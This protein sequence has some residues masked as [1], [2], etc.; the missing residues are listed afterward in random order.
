M[1]TEQDL[2]QDV[3]PFRDILKRVLIVEPDA[4][5]AERRYLLFRKE[6]LGST[7]VQRVSEAIRNIQ[8]VHF[9]AV[10]LDVDVKDMAWE[11]AVPIIKGLEPG[12][13]IIITATLNTPEQEAKVLRSKVFYYHVK[14]FGTEELILAIR[15]AVENRR[16]AK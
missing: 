16:I 1:D 4:R 3:I 11:E 12:L 9:R 5:Q 6:K 8:E 2:N 14:S 13:P 15:N 10:I 7:A